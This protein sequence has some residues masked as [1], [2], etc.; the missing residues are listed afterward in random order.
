MYALSDALPMTKRWNKVEAAVHSVVLDIFP[1]EA[2]LIS[3]VLFKL[4]VYVVCDW[5]PAE[6]ID[7]HEP[8]SQWDTK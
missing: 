5:L 2:T 7:K 6:I 3:E 4:L 1:V 8:G